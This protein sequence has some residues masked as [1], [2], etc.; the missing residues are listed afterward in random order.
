MLKINYDK[1]FQIY[2]LDISSIKRFFII[3][4]AFGSGAYFVLKKFGYHEIFS[5]GGSM[6]MTEGVKRM[7][8]L[9]ARR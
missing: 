9:A 5:I 2:I 3:D 7:L 6:V 1:G 8:R 4:L